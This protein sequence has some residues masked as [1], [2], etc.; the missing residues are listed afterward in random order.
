MPQIHYSL[1]VE[2]A[3]YLIVAIWLHVA[4]IRQ[5][6]M[7][8]LVWWKEMNKE[9][10]LQ[11]ESLPRKRK[12]SGSK[13]VRA[14]CGG[15]SLFSSEKEHNWP[16][17]YRKAAFELVFSKLASL[18]FHHLMRLLTYIW[19]ATAASCCLVWWVTRPF[20]Y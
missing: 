17:K 10:I 2:D 7:T 8:W 6:A 5:M 1:V 20:N 3:F 16:I 12:F 18:F 14:S 15:L 9:G 11:D 4:G 19:A 13:T